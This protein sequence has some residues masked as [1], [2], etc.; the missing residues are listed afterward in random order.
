VDMARR[1]YSMGPLFSAVTNSVRV[2][3]VGSLHLNIRTINVLRSH[4]IKSIGQLL[5]SLGKNPRILLARGARTSDDLRDSLS[6]LS[7]S[8]G[9]SRGV[10]WVAYAR[11]RKL[12]I[13]PDNERN[14]WTPRAFVQE[15][16][17]VA[18][19]SVQIRFGGS[20][21]SV[22]Q[23]H[24]LIGSR[25]GTSLAQTARDLGVSRERARKIAASI[26]E[27]FV[28]IL[29][30]DNYCGCKFRILPKFLN[31]LRTLSA[32]L[33][34]NAN[35][36]LAYSD[37]ESLLV[38]TWRVRPLEVASVERLLLA[39]LGF[40]R[41][42]SPETTLRPVIVSKNRRDRRLHAALRHIEHLLT[43]QYPDGLRSR[44]LLNA[45][46]DKFGPFAPSL[47]EIPALV[48]SMAAVEEVRPDGRYRARGW[49]LKNP[50]NQY[51]RLLRE[52]GKPLHFK[53][54]THQARRATCSGLIQ[55][56]AVTK[57]LTED[58]RFVAVAQ[59]GLW[60]L[61]EWGDIETRTITNIAADL[62]E[63]AGGPIDQD[64]LYTLIK[65]RRPVARDSIRA[66][67][68]RDGRF[69]RAGIQMWSLRRMEQGKPSS[70]A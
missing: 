31:P 69:R 41:V 28:G 36:V 6:S 2:Q 67:L 18:K 56:S 15:L 10:D 48:R 53:E 29:Q 45:L 5:D 50:A 46:A 23:D 58:S 17:R 38:K 59:S 64:R 26:V 11:R 13:L 22:L 20:G 9:R 24:F 19:T 35:G 43:V 8:L 66:L 47:T 1:L 32:A 65:A 49:S 7:L 60:A 63:K 27:M 25:R 42:D 37:W 40:R 62:I 3:R 61:T 44:E 55:S 54:I 21:L 68:D 34:S 16:V 33:E 14:E 57:I 12:T 70:K 39:V 4:H 30:E 52:A 51:E